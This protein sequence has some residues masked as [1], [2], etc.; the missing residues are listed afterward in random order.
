[1]PSRKRSKRQKSKGSHKRCWQG[2]LARVDNIPLEILFEIFCHLEDPGNLLRLAQTS[3]ALRIILM[4]KSSIRIWRTVRARV[5]GLPPLP[6]DLN[7]PQ[8]ASL[9]YESQ[10]HMCTQ[11]NRSDHIL[12]CIRMRS[13]SKCTS[14]QFYTVD[15]LVS[16]VKLDPNVN[17]SLILPCEVIRTRR[18]HRK[19]DK[20]T[21]TLVSHISIARLYLDQYHKLQSN[22]EREQWFMDLQI[23]KASVEQHAGLCEVWFR[24]RAEKKLNQIR[25]ER[26]LAI[27]K[28]LYQTDPLLVKEVRYM[29][30]GGEDL[31]ISHKYVRQAKKLTQRGWNRIK[32]ELVWLLERHRKERTAQE[33]DENGSDDSSD[34]ESV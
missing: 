27:L 4:S 21:W 1:M 25:T 6:E 14:T 11:K 33:S 10:C 3:K 2:I 30:Y 20:S 23:K 29:E 31:F 28:K 34:D 22:D 17:W 26:R 19:H 16:L 15:E 7:E 18:L 24:V 8:F 13:C 32:R 9:I 12:W 5:E